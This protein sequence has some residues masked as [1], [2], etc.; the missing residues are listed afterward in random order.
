MFFDWNTIIFTIDLQGLSLPSTLAPGTAAHIAS[1]YAV[2]TRN[3]QEAEAFI[4]ERRYR[5]Q[6]MAAQSLRLHMLATRKKSQETS[7]EVARFQLITNNVIAVANAHPQLVEARH[8][9]NLYDNLQDP[10]ELQRFRGKCVHSVHINHVAK[11][12]DL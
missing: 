9:D 4:A 2:E 7:T 6:L 5:Q 3:I 8:V 10:A 1:A 12:E 11:K